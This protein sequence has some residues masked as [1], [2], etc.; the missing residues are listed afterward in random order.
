MHLTFSYSDGRRVEGVV[1]SVS[2]DR[3]RV[4]VPGAGDAVE[5]R[6]EQDSWISET[7]EP[8]EIE[9]IV[10]ASE[11]ARCQELRPLTR[12]ASGSVVI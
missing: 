9:S 3:M 10:W 4:S 1:L 6:I 12:T 8:V 2:A 5:L 11:S 7:G